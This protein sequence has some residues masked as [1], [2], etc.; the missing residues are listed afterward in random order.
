[1]P[2]VQTVPKRILLGSG[3]VY[4]TEWDGSTVPD[5][6][7]IK[8]PENLFS[9]IQGGAQLEYKPSFYEAEDDKGR[10]KKTIITKEEAT[11]KTGLMTFNGHSLAKLSE[12]ARVTEDAEK[13]RRTLKIGGI[14]NA[15]GKN[16]VILFHHEDKIDGDVYVMIVGKNQSGFTLGFAKDKE[17]IVDAEF[18]A[19]PHDDEGTLIQYIEEDKSIVAKG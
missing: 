15:N 10:V 18:K 19:I 5:I 14:G 6:E 16:Y 7:T 12:T 13:K 2:E 8:L 9:F 17:S 4:L 11:L 3:D 1:M